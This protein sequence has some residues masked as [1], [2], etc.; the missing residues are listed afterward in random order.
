MF[1]FIF[2]DEPDLNELFWKCF[3]TPKSQ[4]IPYDDKLDKL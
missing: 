2:K 4:G 3:D 1:L